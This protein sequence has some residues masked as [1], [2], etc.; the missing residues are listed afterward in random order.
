MNSPFLTAEWRRLVMLNFEIDPVELS[1][2][3]PAGTEID[4][5]EGKTFVSLVAFQF[6]HTKVLGVPIPFHRNF[7]EVNL[8]FYVRHRASGEWRRGV[9]FVREVVPRF[10]I[11]AVARWIYKENYVSLPMRSTLAAPSPQAN[12]RASY[13]WRHAGQWLTIGGEYH[14][15]PFY[16]EPGSQEEFI[17]EHYWGYSSKRNRGTIEYQVEHPQ[18]RVWEAVSTQL[19]GDFAGFYGKQFA[20]SLASSPSSTFVAEGSPV[21]VRQGQAILGTAAN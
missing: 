10:A 7:D 12:G 13:S 9:V 1:E 15:D 19:D 6:L 8:R 5:W 20:N 11:A 17:T 21:T 18:W 16:P 14:G 2:F 3:V 4:F